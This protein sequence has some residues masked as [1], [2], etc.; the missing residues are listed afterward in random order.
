MLVLNVK[1]RCSS[2]QLMGILTCAISRILLSASLSG[3]SFLLDCGVKMNRH[4]CC[5]YT[6][7]GLQIIRIMWWWSSDTNFY[8]DDLIVFVVV[9]A[10]RLLMLGFDVMIPRQYKHNNEL[11]EMLQLLG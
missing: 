5:W 4:F 1:Q 3:F 2:I 6:G 9:S 11:R 7:S 10:K 8:Y